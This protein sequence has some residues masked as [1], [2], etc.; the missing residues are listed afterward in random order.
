MNCIIQ[1]QKITLQTW[2]SRDV[3]VVIPQML[4]CVD[5]GRSC[6]ICWTGDELLLAMSPFICCATAKC[7]PLPAGELLFFSA[8]SD[9][10]CIS[11]S[12]SPTDL[13]L[14]AKL[15]R[16]SSTLGGIQTFACTC[17]ELI[18]SCGA[19]IPIA[20]FAWLAAFWLL[21]CCWICIWID[22]SN[23]LS[24]DCVLPSSDVD[25]R[26]WESDLQKLLNR[27]SARLEMS[28]LVLP[29]PSID[30]EDAALPQRCR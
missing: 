17:L 11:V 9:L 30:T 28:Y 10:L 19:L 24:C 4:H 7:A 5:W 21:I 26:V 29:I 16:S 15:A 13:L 23:G 22:W 27:F 3:S 14:I 6:C 18:C 2:S 1:V 12:T 25:G 8:S 20:V